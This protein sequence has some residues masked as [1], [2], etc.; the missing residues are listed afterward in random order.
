[1]A[2]PVVG[3]RM[4]MNMQ[5][6][7]RLQSG[8]GWGTSLQMP[9]LDDLRRNIR[10]AIDEIGVDLFRLRGCVK[11]RDVDPDAEAIHI[12]WGIVGMMA[13][14]RHLIPPGPITDEI[15]RQPSV[16][17]IPNS[18]IAELAEAVAGPG[19]SEADEPWLR[20]S[21]A[22][23]ASLAEIMNAAARLP[24]KRQL[25]VFDELGD[26]TIRLAL[27]VHLA[28]LERFLRASDDPRA[29]REAVE[30]ARDYFGGAVVFAQYVKS[31]LLRAGIDV[32]T[33]GA[34]FDLYK[35]HGIVDE[36]LDRLRV[37]VRSAFEESISKN[38]GY[39]LAFD[40]IFRG[41][42]GRVNRYVERLASAGDKNEIGPA[43]LD[44][45]GK[46]KP[47]VFPLESV[48][49]RVSEEIEVDEPRRN[50]EEIGLDYDTFRE[51]HS[52]FLLTRRSA[53]AAT[54]GI[55]LTF[56]IEWRT[57]C[58]EVESY[59]RAVIGMLTDLDRKRIDGLL[60]GAEA[61]HLEIDEADT[62]LANSS[63]GERRDQFRRL[64]SRRSP[65]LLF[66]RPP[67]GT[68][69]REPHPDPER[70]AREFGAT[71]RFFTRGAEAAGRI[72]RAAV[73]GFGTALLAALIIDD[74]IDEADRV[75]AGF[76]PRPRGPRPK[77]LSESI[78]DVAAM[79]GISSS[80][81]AIVDAVYPRVR[82]AV[83]FDLLGSNRSDG[84]KG[85]Q[86]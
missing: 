40:D 26:E 2:H 36:T 74:F 59:L 64:F 41:L 58:V 46:D 82:A 10:D 71:T 73:D 39:E 85:A 35:N 86:R 11:V 50:L 24:E 6:Y 84:E 53:H 52:W 69:R 1:M 25:A 47:A 27:E 37:T 19:A 48:R 42:T 9:L 12:V 32:K 21:L 80:E 45:D 34:S 15:V 22:N 8:K 68:S 20:S 61:R 79:F 83:V 78:D 62:L 4:R 3:F 49:L 72:G 76:G 65:A 51:A 54:I 30:Q 14:A 63:I 44:G 29:A 57:A 17:G 38:G 43:N 5:T 56:P 18:I 31:K 67:H 16:I 28:H 23:R 77:A 81:T 13:R 66:L 75:P 33:Q 55:L 60:F 7:A 70:V